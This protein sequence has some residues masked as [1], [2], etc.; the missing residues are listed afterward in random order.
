MIARIWN[1]YTNPE[2]ANAYEDFLVNELVPS[3]KAKNIAGYKGFQLLRQTNNAE[4]TFKTIFYFDTQVD[5]IAFAGENYQKA[6]VP[7][8]ARALLSRFD[9]A[10]DH[11]EVREDT[12]QA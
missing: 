2:N 4:I 7:E 11:F 3:I 1:G 5:L 8:K 10:V 6:F 12:R 9:A